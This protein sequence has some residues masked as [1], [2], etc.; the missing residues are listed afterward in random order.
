MSITK[1][2]LIELL[3]KN[4]YQRGI[5]VNIFEIPKFKNIS[6]KTLSQ[7]IYRLNKNEFIERKSTGYI[8]TNS[9]KKYIGKKMQE[10]QIFSKPK[11]MST[12]K[13]LLVFFDIPEKKKKEREWFRFHLKKFDYNMIQH[14][15]WVG[16]DPLPTEFLDY[17]KSIELDDCIETIKLAKPYKSKKP[18]SSYFAKLRNM[19]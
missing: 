10:L 5:P 9:G 2:I 8:I 16:P 12:D 11:N 7:T 17:I 13:I 3:N 15:V 6:K 4:L 19:I 14:S 1:G 18:A